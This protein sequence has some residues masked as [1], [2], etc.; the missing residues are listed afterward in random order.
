MQNLQNPNHIAIIMD[1]NNRWAKEKNLPTKKGHQEGSKKIKQ[2]IKYCI[3][4]QIKYLTLYAFS[5]ENW[6]RPK[7]EIND[8]FFLIK[9]YIDKDISDLDKY[10]VKIVICGDLSQIEKS[11]KE[12]II[13]LTQ[14]TQNN[15]KI[16]VNIAFNYGSRDEI[17]KAVK[18]IAQKIKKEEIQIDDINEDLISQNLYQPNIPDPDLVIR[19]GGFLRM[20]NFLLWQS[21]YSELY[22]TDIF[23]P[24]FSEKHL[25]KAIENFN[26]RKRNY[27]NR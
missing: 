17:T 12:K 19:T 9:N 1:G 22:F 25:D 7:K 5:T 16:I 6:K 4:L 3:K 24:D 18:N 26:L 23:W 10:G 11:L 8:L 15:N 2:I 13:K 20:S 14:K 27:G 21:S